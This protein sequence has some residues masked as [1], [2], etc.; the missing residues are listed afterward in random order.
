MQPM[1]HPASP[2]IMV[3]DDYARFFPTAARF[4]QPQLQHP[5]RTF[6]QLKKPCAVRAIEFTAAYVWREN[7][8]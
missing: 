2:P 7:D 1:L 6:K 8:V 3:L 5:R 4:S